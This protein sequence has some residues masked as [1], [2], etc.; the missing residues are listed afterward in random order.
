MGIKLTK[1]LQYLE[2]I[3][4][5]VN[6]FPIH[7]FRLGYL[8]FSFIFKVIAR[9]NFSLLKTPQFAYTCSMSPSFN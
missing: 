6:T 2:Q 4:I 8:M 9:Y 5:D 3:N 7:S 1:Y